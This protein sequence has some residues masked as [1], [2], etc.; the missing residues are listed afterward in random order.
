MRS[1]RYEHLRPVERLGETVAF[2]GRNGTLELD[3]VVGGLLDGVVL[4]FAHECLCSGDEFRVSNI[5]VLESPE[6]FFDLCTASM[7]MSRYARV[8]VQDI[9]T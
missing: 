1:S 3:E 2:I 5:H 9:M 7:I 6:L 8:H 4:E